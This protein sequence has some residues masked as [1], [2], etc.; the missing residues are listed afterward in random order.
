[1]LGHCGLDAD[2][3]GS[4]SLES[5]SGGEEFSAALAASAGPYNR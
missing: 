2:A 5:F 4:E 3:R 1:M